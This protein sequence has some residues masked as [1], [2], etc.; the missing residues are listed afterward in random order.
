MKRINKREKKIIWA[1]SLGIGVSLAVTAIVT[2]MFPN[3][4]LIFTADQL[5]FMALVLSIFPPAMADYLDARW[6]IS[7]DK[8]IPEFLRELSEAG[9]TGL[10]LTRAVEQASKRRYGPLSS[11]LERVVIKLSWG[12]NLEAALKDFSERVG[13]RLAKRV[14][15]LLSEIHRAGGEIKD[16]LEIVSKYAGELQTIEEERRSQLKMYVLVI[17]IA[18][19]IFLFVDVLLLKTFFAR[20]ESLKVMIKQVGGLFL[21][22]DLSSVRRLMLHICIIEGLFGGLVAGKMGE[23]AFGAGLKHSMI[24]MIIGF[25]TFS[26]PI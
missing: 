1:I 20:L 17:Y 7:A 16:V 24:L 11:E 14:S 26:F 19:L 4:S 13:T 15:V 6:K 8:N 18:F 3:P 12:G 21:V 9:R 22:E 23:G 5:F 2:N 25:M 10:T